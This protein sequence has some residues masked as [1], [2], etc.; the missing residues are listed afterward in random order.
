MITLI[1]ILGFVIFLVTNFMVTKSTGNYL[2][3]IKDGDFPVFE[4][5]NESSIAVASL[6]EMLVSASGSG[7]LDE[8]ENAKTLKQKIDSDL[9]TIERVTPENADKINTIRKELDNY[10]AVA[11]QVAQA[12]I[13]DTAD[14]DVLQ[15]LTPQME[16]SYSTVVS[17]LGGL[18]ESVKQIFSNRLTAVEGENKATW[19]LSASLSLLIIVVLVVFSIY[20]TRVLTRDL[21]HAVLVADKIAEG[22]W[23]TQIVIKSNDETGHLLGAISTMRDKLK[24]RTEEDHRKERL[25]S[26]IADLNERMRGDQNIEELCRNILDYVTPVTSCQV[27]AIYFFESDVG[28]LSLIGSYAFTHRKGVQNH[29]KL[30]ESLVGQCALEKKQILVSHLPDGYLTISSGLGSSTPKNVLLTPILYESNLMA[31]IELASFEHIDDLSMEFLQS[32]IDSM[33]IAINSVLS[34]AKLA[35]MLDKTRQQAESMERQQE[36]LRASNEE[37]EEQTKALRRSEENLQ[38]QQEELRVTNE[39]LSEQAKILE[40]QK[41][42][43]AQQ[44]QALEK[45]QKILKE[46]SDALELSSKYKSEFLSTMSHELRTPLNSIL[47][48]SSNL[49]GNKKGNLDAKQIE[50]CQVIHSAGSDLLTLINDI[51][52]LSKVEEGKLQI[53]LEELPMDIL[54]RNIQLN[55]E[56]VAKAKNVEFGIS[57]A[58]NLPKTFVTDRQRLEQILKNLLSN[59]FK[60]T[61]KGGVYLEITRPTPAML[62]YIPDFSPASTLALTVRDS[63][64]GIPK[65]K[66][67]LVFE[68]FQQVDG[69]TSRKYGGTGLGLTI[70]RQLAKLLKGDLLITQSEPGKG[71]SFTLF[72]PDVA[73]IEGAQTLTTDHENDIPSVSQAVQL[74]RSETKTSLPVQERKEEK[75]KAQEDFKPAAL[76]SS[77]RAVLIIEDDQQFA[78]LLAD[79]AQEHG[80][81]T[82]ICHDGESGLSYAQEYKPSAI[83]LDVGL[84]GMDGFQVMEH[85]RQHKST[86]AIPVHFVSGDDNAEKALALGAYEFLKKPISREQVELSFGKIEQ[87][88]K[89]QFNRILVIEDNKVSHQDILDTFNNKKIEVIS[90]YTGAEAIQAL[91]DHNFDFMILDLELPDMDGF[92]LLEKINDDNQLSPVPVIVYTAKDLTRNEEAKLRKYADRIILKTAKSSERLLSEASLFLHWLDSSNKDIAKQKVLEPIDHRADIFKG[93]KLLVVDDDMRNIYSLTV[94]LEEK[95]FDIEIATNGKE[96]LDVLAQSP[97]KDMVLMDIMMP[98]MDGYEAMTEIRKNDRF[99]KL[100]IIAL[101]AKAMKNDKQK[102]IEAGANDYITKPIDADKLLSL[103]RVWLQ[104]R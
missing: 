37:L 51:L 5:V 91:K 96:A 11:E 42:E 85:L 93:K 43:M 9:L 82:H 66:Q 38:A 31:V 27:G 59:A 24:S 103:M 26:Q 75:P 52:D 102:C 56:H 78:S 23:D 2:S 86:Q 90:A 39:E 89:S 58:D 101:T 61:E 72:L 55:F 80:I 48:L 35:E 68:A 64:I 104:K 14:A 62:S 7:E 3:S 99:A 32:V 4:V 19:L 22:E 45:A 30:G 49:A 16:K 60:F 25:Q 34:R 88:L 40:H 94:I 98:E 28:Q 36:E 69:T 63:G 47:I 87:A 20:I 73:V 81:K 74:I 41:I 12:M 21:N 13:S 33:G 70:S 18:R 71:S 10:Y 76:P 6:K 53:V 50:H 15:K 57:I 67:H 1:S 77:E 29:Y 17:E 79:L 65:E 46:K 84:P 54:Q 92:A 100:P 95:G 44:N 83:I 97:D 8:L